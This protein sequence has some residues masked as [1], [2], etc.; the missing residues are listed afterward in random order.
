MLI[1]EAKIV[2]GLNHPNI[3][4][5]FELGEEGGTH[6][7]AMEYVNGTDLKGLVRAGGLLP[8]EV[9][10]PLFLGTLAGLGCAHQAGVI[11]RDISPQNLLISSEGIAKIADFGI[12][13]AAAVSRTTTS[14]VLK[15]KFCYMSPEQAQGDP[16]DHRSDLFSAGLVFFEMLTGRRLYE[17]ES[18]LAILEC[19]RR[20]EICSDEGSWGPIPTELRELLLPALS[21][22]PAGRYATAG[23]FRDAVLQFSRKRGLEPSDSKVA[24]FVAVSCPKVREEDAETKS[25]GRAA[26]RKGARPWAWSLGLASLP[27]LIF[28]LTLSLRGRFPPPLKSAAGVGELSVLAVPWAYVR[29]DGSRR[30]ETPV[31]DLA[32]EEGSH[33]VWLFYEPENRVVTSQV[34]VKAGQKIRCLA[35]FE[36][37][38]GM[39]CR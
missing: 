10:I 37:G 25:L 11:H 7:V 30:M 9:A 23:E 15:G 6:F 1:R 39:R 28:G 26:R 5:V 13:R 12:A 31:K 19:A 17:G 18:D 24:D 20:A 22:D 35:D 21:K 4:Q 27:L 2:V 33:Q 3:V 36:K 38:E 32:L 14:G 34:T 29:V 8:L 16:L